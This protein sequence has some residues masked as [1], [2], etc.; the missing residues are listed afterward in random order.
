MGLMDG[1]MEMGVGMGVWG[2]SDAHMHVEHDKHGKHGCLHVNSHLQFLYMYSC[3]H[4]ACAC[5]HVHVGTPPMP[6]EPPPSCPLPRATGSP[7]H[8][9]PISPKLIKIIR[10]CLKILYL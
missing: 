5:M 6:P 3:A 8:Q 10:F 7:K 9:N 4:C 1:W 2:L